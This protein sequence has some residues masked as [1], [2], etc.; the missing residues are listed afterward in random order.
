[1]LADPPACDPANR[2]RHEIATEFL[3]FSFSQFEILEPAKS[4]GYRFRPVKYFPLLLRRLPVRK[5]QLL[6]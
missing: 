5:M 6:A 4:C 2:Y 3:R 1:L